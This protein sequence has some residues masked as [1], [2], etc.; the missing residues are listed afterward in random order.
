[1]RRRVMVWVVLLGVTVAYGAT[2]PAEQAQRSPVVAPASAVEEILRG[3]IAGRQPVAFDYHGQERVVHPHR[4]GISATGKTLLRAWEVS[5]AGA[6]TG[7]WKLYDLRKLRA[8]R[9][10][11]ASA[12]FP[13]APGYTPADKALRTLLAEVPYDIQTPKA[14]PP[15]S[16]PKQ[17]P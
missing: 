3:A 10:L 4:L 11:P 16:T 2:A 17:E 1:M 9:P 7:Q 15:Q 8:P 5:K 13:I 6:P 14:P 12:P